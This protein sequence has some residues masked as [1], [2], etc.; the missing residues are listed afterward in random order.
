MSLVTSTS[1][2]P[3]PGMIATIMVGVLAFSAFLAWMAGWEGSRAYRFG[4]RMEQEPRYARRHL[5]RRGMMYVGCM[6][7][8]IVLVATGREPKKALIVLP[9]GVALAWTSFRAAF[10]VKVPPA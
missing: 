1:A 7:L 5:L 3:S 10:R 9:I 6:V 8:F 4:G 2:A